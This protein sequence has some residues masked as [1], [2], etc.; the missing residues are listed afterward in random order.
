ME[1]ITSTIGTLICGSS[2][3]GSINT[4]N[5]P[6]NTDV[7]MTSGVSLESMNARAMRPAMPSDPEVGI[8]FSDFI[9]SGLGLRR[10]SAA[11]T[12]LSKFGGR[13]YFGELSPKRCRASLAT[14]VQNLAVV[15]MI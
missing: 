5:T 12:A 4:A 9:D 14:A 1:T 6:S 13:V 10:Q 15:R 2:S 8:G 3:R 7:M 11:A